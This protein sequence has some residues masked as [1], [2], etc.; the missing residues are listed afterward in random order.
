MATYAVINMREAE[1]PEI[2]GSVELPEEEKGGEC[3]LWREDTEEYK[4][5]GNEIEYVFVHAAT[6]REEDDERRNCLAC[7]RCVNIVAPEPK[8]VADGGF[9]T[10]ASEGDIVVNMTNDEL[11]GNWKSDLENGEVATFDTE[12]F[13]D[14]VEDGDRVYFEAGG[15]LYAQATIREVGDESVWATGAIRLRVTADSPVEVPEGGF[16]RIEED[17]ALPASDRN[18]SSDTVVDTEASR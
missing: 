4:P 2:Y 1:P 16:A 11:S 6:N 14:G 15:L 13:P 9:S 5:C 7:E 18:I 3:S 12:R 17:G 8:L 10:I